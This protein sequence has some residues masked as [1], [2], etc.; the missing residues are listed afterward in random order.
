MRFPQHT[1]EPFFFMAQ[2]SEPVPLTEVTAPSGAMG[3]LCRLPAQR[4]VLLHTA[5]LYGVATDRGKGSI[6]PVWASPVTG[7]PAIHLPVGP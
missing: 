3:W 7:S 6:R 4:L 1:S 2:A 5:P